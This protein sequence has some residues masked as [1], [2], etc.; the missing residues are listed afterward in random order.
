[1]PNSARLSTR[2]LVAGV[3]HARSPRSSSTYSVPAPSSRRG[4]KTISLADSYRVAAPGAA[5]L[6]WKYC[7]RDEPLSYRFDWTFPGSAYGKLWL[8]DFKLPS[9]CTLQIV[10]EVVAIGLVP[11]ITEVKM[12]EIVYTILCSKM[13][14][15][16]I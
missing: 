14:C 3:I 16:E 13:F 10:Y 6:N 11:R 9:R 15:W 1:M 2:L 5:V 12:M 4:K 7:A 8:K